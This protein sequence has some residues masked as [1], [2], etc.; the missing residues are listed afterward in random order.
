V[1]HRE[2]ADEVAF[3]R[4]IEVS[5]GVACA[6]AFTALVDWIRRR[7]RRPPE[8]APPSAGSR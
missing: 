3:F 6:A 7:R 5:Y 8:E 4:F 1:P 2:P